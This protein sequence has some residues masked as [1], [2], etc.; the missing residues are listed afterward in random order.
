MT[1][2]LNVSWAFAIT[3]SIE[4]QYLIQ[5]NQIISLSEQ[6][7]IDCSGFGGCNTGFPSI[8]LN[9]VIQNKLYK[10][11]DY[12]YTQI[13]GKCNTTKN[14]GRPTFNANDTVIIQGIPI[15]KFETIF[16]DELKMK[17]A[18]DTIVNNIYI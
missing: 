12:R 5:Y 14:I 9:Y 13:K 6:N 4:S 1:F 10:N 18:I 7:L 8:G 3:G 17:I 11:T 16:N 15:S 2:V